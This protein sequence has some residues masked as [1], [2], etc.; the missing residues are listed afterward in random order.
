MENVAFVV[1][2]AGVLAFGLLSAKADRGVVTPPMAFTFF[3][4][5]IGASGIGLVD[6]MLS[7]EAIHFLAEV[8]LVVVLFTDASRIDLKRLRR[9]HGLPVRLLGLGM[10][11]TLVA[12]GAAALAVLPELGF[13]EALLLS[14]ILMPTD[15]ALGQ[16]VVSSPRVPERIRQALNVES[17]LNDGIALPV[18]LVLFSLACASAETQ[19]AAYW[20]RFMAGQV[21]LGPLAGVVVGWVGGRLVALA[22]DRGWMTAVFRDL[23]FLA[24]AFLAYGVA[25][26]IHGNG[27]IAA[28]TA[29]MVVGGLARDLGKLEEFAEAEGQI[30][31]LGVFLVF[32]AVMVPEIL[33]EATWRTLL[34]A[35]LSLTVVRML[36]VALSL[37]G[38]GV[39]PATVLFLGWFGPRGLAS[40]LFALL[41]VDALGAHEH[42]HLLPIVWLT[43][44]L[45][46][47]LHGVSA[48]PLAGAYRRHLERL[49]E[50]RAQT[51][52]EMRPLEAGAIHPPTPR[53]EGR[54]PS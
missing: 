18:V 43:V 27:F 8:T 41:V 32:G 9:D 29:G 23:T 7:G 53:E 54:G 38:A 50:I 49:G 12:G 39:R 20:L 31:A 13:W 10:P 2:A 48:N 5:L 21:L 45:S 47:V 17:G 51:Q 36:P 28:F 6:L 37:L 26:L 1:I 40:I 15:A 33:A 19:S 30:L 16:A 4:C 11:L 25:E 22:H 34:Y 14:S 46:I 3:G 24:I 44:L 52:E 35:L 42:G